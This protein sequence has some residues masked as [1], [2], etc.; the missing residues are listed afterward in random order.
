LRFKILSDG[1]EFEA[2][3]RKDR[4]DRAKFAKNTRGML[5]G[6]LLAG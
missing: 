2:F 5:I 4:E 6:K 1:G 3:N